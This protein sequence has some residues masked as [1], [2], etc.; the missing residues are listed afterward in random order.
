MED[1]IAHGA[2]RRLSVDIAN[3]SGQLAVMQSGLEYVQQVASNVTPDD[4]DKVMGEDEEGKPEM[5]LTLKGD[6]VDSV[7]RL[8]AAVGTLG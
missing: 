5:H 8:L 6:Q 4:W 3:L 2:I 7:L 1:A